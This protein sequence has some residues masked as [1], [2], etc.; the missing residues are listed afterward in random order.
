MAVLSVDFDHWASILAA[1]GHYGC[2]DN[3][4]WFC[5][6]RLKFDSLDLSVQFCHSHLSFSHK[7]W[8]IMYIWPILVASASVMAVMAADQFRHFG[9]NSAIFC[10]FD[11]FYHS[12]IRPQLAVLAIFG[13]SQHSVLNFSPFHHFGQFCHFSLNFGYCGH[14]WQ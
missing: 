8:P 4:G 13:W 14:F 11:C 7:L 2:F 3:F 9:P 1:L 5:H 10:H 12:V 6:F